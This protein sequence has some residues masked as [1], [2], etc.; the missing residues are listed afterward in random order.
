MRLRDM[1]QADLERLVLNVL[2]HPHDE[3]GTTFVMCHNRAEAAMR[4]MERRERRA[5][6]RERRSARG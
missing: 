3:C 6:R 5:I 4:E 2:T 1:T